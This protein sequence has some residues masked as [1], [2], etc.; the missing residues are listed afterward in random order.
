MADNTTMLALALNCIVADVEGI[1]VDISIIDTLV[2]SQP[3]PD[4]PNPIP[5]TKDT[6]STILA[7][8]QNV[9]V[10]KSLLHGNQ[11]RLLFQVICKVSKSDMFEMFAMSYFC[12]VSDVIK[13][14]FS[15]FKYLS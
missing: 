10:F 12:N 13:N 4:G 1:L 11:H 14:K 6:K 15:K 9:Q 2:I 3:T 5:S 8:L 7:K